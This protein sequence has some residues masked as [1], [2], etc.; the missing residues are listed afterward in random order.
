MQSRNRL[1]R[2]VCLLFALSAASISWGQTALATITGTIVDATGAVIANASI[3]VRNLENGQ[4]STASS[5][6]TGNYSVLQLPI[7]DYDMT[8]TV[9]GFKTYTHT[10]FHLAAAQVMREDVTLEVG[11]TTE[12]VTVTAEASLLKTETTTVAQ[13]VTLA[14]LNNLPVLGVGTTGSG[15]RDPFASVR[16]TAGIQYNNGQNGAPVVATNM[17]VNGTPANTYGT[18]LDGMTMNPTGSRLLANQMQTQPST[19]AI[20]EVAIMTSNFAA[21]YGAAGGA[22]INMVTK[23]G[24]NA[25][26]GSL[27][28]YG[29]NEALYAHQPYVY[30]RPKIRQ[31]D[32]GGTFGGPVRIPKL[33][34]GTN[35]TFF[36]FSMELFKQFN[37]LNG[38]VSVP[39]SAYR[40]GDFSALIPAENRLVTT[41]AGAYLDPL[42]RNIPSGTIFDPTTQRAVGT[43][44]VRDPFVGNK[45]PVARFDPVAVKVLSYVPLPA[46]T[47]FEKGL[48]VG[49]YI[50]SWNA[51]RTSKIPS[52]K[53]DQ[54][55]GASSRLSFYLQETNT[56]SPRSPA[57]ADAMPDQITGGIRTFSAGTTARVNLDHNL[58]SRLLLH[59]GIGW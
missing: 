47:N 1:A 44:Q 38:S 7:G 50:G 39:T 11:Q 53:L 56:R 54:N 20:E 46:G 27:Y 48:A 57:G 36:F 51:D 3:S 14:Q 49:N 58:S 52:I 43:S 41:A 37:M 23:S 42:G 21:E 19:D 15:F 13:N 8:I 30:L 6:E 10:A 25:F 59:L 17:V 31:N 35:K 18:R 40:N 33:Y 32:M 26:H 5:S 45:I 29:T 24:T 34:N 12:S 2:V 9:A 4:V 16:L 28:D 22:M 55:I